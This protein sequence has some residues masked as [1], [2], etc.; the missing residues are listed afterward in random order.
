MQNF[1]EVKTRSFCTFVL[2]RTVPILG[3]A[4]WAVQD[5][6]LGQRCCLDIIHDAYT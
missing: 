1:A 2:A 6:L 3:F 5:A 4:A